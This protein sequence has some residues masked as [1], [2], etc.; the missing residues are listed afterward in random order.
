MLE[1]ICIK[2]Q[3]EW[4][5][6]VINN[7]ALENSAMTEKRKISHGASTNR[8]VVGDQNK[9]SVSQAGES[10]IEQRLHDTRRLCRFWQ[11]Y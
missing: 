11:G 2:G 1:Q 3:F 4:D 7:S 6:G 5:D 10:Y 9:L 8:T